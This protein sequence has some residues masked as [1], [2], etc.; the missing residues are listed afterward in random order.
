MTD[1]STSVRSGVPRQAIWVATSESRIG[2]V[3]GRFSRTDFSRGPRTGWVPAV[4]A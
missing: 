4:P 3:H 2:N 1:V